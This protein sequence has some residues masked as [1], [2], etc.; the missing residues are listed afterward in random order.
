MVGTLADVEVV[1]TASGI[2]VVVVESVALVQDE[3]NAASH[4]PA[5]ASHLRF[6]VNVPS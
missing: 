5:T 2:L 6:S 4:K 1:E 3:T